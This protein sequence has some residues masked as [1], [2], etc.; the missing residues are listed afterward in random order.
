M[1]VLLSSKN[2][3][4]GPVNVVGYRGKR[5]LGAWNVM[6]GTSEGFVAQTEAGPV[7]LKWQLPGGKPQSK[8]FILENAPVKFVLP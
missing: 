8:D 7:T 3:Y 4:V 5:C 6:P 2:S 1:R